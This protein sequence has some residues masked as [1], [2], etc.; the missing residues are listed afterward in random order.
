MQNA[1]DFLF[2]NDFL[3]T[4]VNGLE[5]QL[6][7]IS[8]RSQNLGIDIEFEIHVKKLNGMR[9]GRVTEAQAA[10][11]NATRITRK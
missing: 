11:I 10:T 7:V 8:F 3:E 9:L 6:T 2:F 1:D 4:L 5:Q